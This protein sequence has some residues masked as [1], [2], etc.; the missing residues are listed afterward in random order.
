MD[1]VQ[2]EKNNKIFL[3]FLTLIIG[4]IILMSVMLIVLYYDT[5]VDKKDNNITQYNKTFT[6][7]TPK[8]AYELIN[9]TEKLVVIDCREGCNKCQFNHGHLPRATMN[10]DP[11][12]LYQNEGDHQNATDILVYSVDGLVGAEF[13]GMLVDHVNGEI[14]NL[15]GGY[16]AWVAAGYPT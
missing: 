1:E 10:T 15:A 5:S 4:A 11:T 6:T 8:E 14:Y 9:T 12:T 16:D 7:I 3:I 13:C 2:P